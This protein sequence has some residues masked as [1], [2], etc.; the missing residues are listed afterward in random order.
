[1]WRRMTTANN[2]AH[3]SRT[4]TPSLARC[5]MSVTRDVAGFSA[6][7]LAVRFWQLGILNKH[8]FSSA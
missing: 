2:K 4:V 5:T 7:G 1:M 6:F 3:L 8:L